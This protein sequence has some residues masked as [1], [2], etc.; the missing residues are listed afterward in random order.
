MQIKESKYK[1]EIQNF[2]FLINDNIS[3]RVVLMCEP[4]SHASHSASHASHS[5]SHSANHTS[6]SAS[7]AS[8]NASH[9][10]HAS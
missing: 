6:H 5:A 10:S 8:H 3:F 2:L 4:A 1:C 9:A 7:H